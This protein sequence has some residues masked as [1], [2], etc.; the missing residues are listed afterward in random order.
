MDW[1]QIRQH[2]PGQWV[3]VEAF[4]AYTEGDQRVIPRL[5]VIGVH[6]D[7]RSAWEHYKQLHHADRLREYYMLHTDR[8]ELDIG[9][10]DGFRRVVRG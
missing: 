4:D 2:Y 3:V 7:W 9:V 6:D 8:T 5:E 10:M 1:S